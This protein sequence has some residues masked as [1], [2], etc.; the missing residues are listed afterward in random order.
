VNDQ[1]FELAVQDLAKRRK[2]LLALVRNDGWCWDDVIVTDAS[3]YLLNPK[4]FP[5]SR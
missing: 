4:V 1:A 5:Q 2:L 3:P